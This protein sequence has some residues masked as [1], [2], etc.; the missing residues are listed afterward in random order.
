MLFTNLIILFSSEL[1]TFYFHSVKLPEDSPPRMNPR[2][3]FKPRNSNSGSNSGSNSENEL[4][5]VLQGHCVSND[6]HFSSGKSNPGRNSP[7]KQRQNHCPKNS[8]NKSNN[9][10]RGSPHK[11]QQ[12]SHNV[13]RQL[14]YNSNLAPESKPAPAERANN[15][16]KRSPRKNSPPVCQKQS[17]DFAS[18]K[19]SFSSPNAADVPLPPTH[20]FSGCSR[21][22]LNESTISNQLKVLLNVM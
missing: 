15:K 20:W 10:S 19:L 3:K 1:T 13:K 12:P 21:E 16:S 6:R 14:H 7:P 8:P 22:V 17:E 9:S 4:P 5:A 2:K 11:Q 18:P